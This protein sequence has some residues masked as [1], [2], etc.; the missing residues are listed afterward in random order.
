VITYSTREAAL[1]CTSLLE[2]QRIDKFR[3]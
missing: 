1:A 2:Q 3:A